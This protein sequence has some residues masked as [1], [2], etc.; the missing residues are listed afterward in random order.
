MKYVHQNTTLIGW[1]RKEVV[2]P[3]TPA[4]KTYYRVHY[5]VEGPRREEDRDILVREGRYYKLDGEFWK[6][7]RLVRIRL[8]TREKAW[9]DRHIRNCQKA[10]FG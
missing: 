2:S 10:I 6:K 5:R 4:T 3:A 7:D 1:K 8:V 9:L